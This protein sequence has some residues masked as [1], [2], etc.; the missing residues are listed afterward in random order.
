MITLKEN[1]INQIGRFI[2]IR[3]SEDVPLEGLVGKR[4]WIQIH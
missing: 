1:P 4:I 2:S 3:L